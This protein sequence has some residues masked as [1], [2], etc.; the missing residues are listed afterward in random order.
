ME[1]A[2]YIRKQR[3]TNPALIAINMAY[4]ILINHSP[5]LAENVQLDGLAKD[6]A[7]A[8]LK[9]AVPDNTDQQ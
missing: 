1:S 6:I 2:D 7:D 5:C 4:G 3:R 8:I 9:G